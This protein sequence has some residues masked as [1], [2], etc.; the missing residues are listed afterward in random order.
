MRVDGL[1][2][3]GRGGVGGAAFDYVRALTKPY[4]SIRGVGV[5]VGGMT[6]ETAVGARVLLLGLA[7]AFPSLEAPDGV[8]CNCP[9]GNKG[10]V[11][12]PI[13]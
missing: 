3:D 2:N 13:L 9:E 8:A 4:S 6:V 10:F 7:Y 12:K 1:G 11:V 5:A